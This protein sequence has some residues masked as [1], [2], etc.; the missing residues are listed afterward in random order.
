M[1]RDRLSKEIDEDVHRAVAGWWAARGKEVVEEQVGRLLRTRGVLPLFKTMM[2]AGQEREFATV[3]SKR[4]GVDVVA[5]EVAGLMIW[6]VETDWQP[7]RG[8]TS[9][10]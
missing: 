5:A 9:P 2:A 3:C 8:L 4:Y 7:S 10:V 6:M 1:D